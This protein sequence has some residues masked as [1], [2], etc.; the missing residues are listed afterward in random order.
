MGGAKIPGADLGQ[1]CQAL[2]AAS[3]TNPATLGEGSVEGL[4]AYYG[5]MS[6]AFANAPTQTLKTNLD[7]VVTFMATL[8]EAIGTSNQNLTMGLDGE[9]FM[10]AMTAVDMEGKQLCS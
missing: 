5:L 10:A 1:F 9:A 8:L 3:E 2:L 4:Q 6:T 7:T